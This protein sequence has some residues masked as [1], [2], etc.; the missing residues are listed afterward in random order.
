[1][2]SVV[3]DVA[4]DQHSPGLGEEGEAVAVPQDLQPMTWSKG[5]VQ[6]ELVGGG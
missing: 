1:M 6:A 5:L 2:V 3:L 4:K